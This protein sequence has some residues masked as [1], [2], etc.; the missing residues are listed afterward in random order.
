[1]PTRKFREEH[2]RILRQA[3]AIAGLANGR[4]TRDAADEARAAILGLDRLL[5]EHLTA[6]D[7]WMYPLLMASPDESVRGAATECFGDMGGIRGAWDAY[8]EL[9]TSEAILEAPIRFRAATDGVIG[10]LAMRVEREN[11]EL[12]PLVD[13]M[14]PLPAEEDQAA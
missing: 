3:S 11:V 13:H 4:M 10:A 14:S 12:Y 8:R 2:D 5:V 6:E 7:E 9:W 1:M